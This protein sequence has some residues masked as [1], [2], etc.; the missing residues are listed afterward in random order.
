MGW[1]GLKGVSSSP[2]MGILTCA[3]LLEALTRACGFQVQRS[4]RNSPS[5]AVD[6]LPYSADVPTMLLIAVDYV[7]YSA[8]G[9]T[10]P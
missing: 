8:D 6:Y 7:P 1:N 2:G 5:I 9:P 10:M 3:V 4:Q